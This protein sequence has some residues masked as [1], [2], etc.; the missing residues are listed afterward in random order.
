MA[1]LKPTKRL[2]DL[3]LSSDFQIFVKHVNLYQSISKQLHPEF[4]HR[5]HHLYVAH[6]KTQKIKEIGEGIYLVSI[7]L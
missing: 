4:N 6:I 5:W 7:F 2:S 1:F 3:Y